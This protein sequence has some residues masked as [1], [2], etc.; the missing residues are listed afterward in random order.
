MRAGGVSLGYA[1]VNRKPNFHALL[2]TRSDPELQNPSLKGGRPPMPPTCCGRWTLNAERRNSFC[3][4]FFSSGLVGKSFMWWIW[5]TRDGPNWA[6]H[7]SLSPSSP[8]VVCFRDS[9]KQHT[10]SMLQRRQ[11]P[12]EHSSHTFAVLPIWCRRRRGR[13]RPAR[14]ARQTEPP[15]EMFLKAQ[16]GRSSHLPL[17]LHRRVI[18]RQR[19]LSSRD[20]AQRPCLSTD[21]LCRTAKAPHARAP[22]E[23]RISHA[24]PISLLT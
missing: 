10:M 2:H 9:E 22:R 15:P 3:S 21:L 7:L 6:A 19:S 14:R 8:R 16:T 23:Y 13:E 18:A 1:Y 4:R 12:S 17:H 24:P 20:T 5:E 11:D